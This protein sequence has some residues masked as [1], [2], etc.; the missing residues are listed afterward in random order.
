VLQKRLEVSEGDG[1]TPKA[2]LRLS[3]A[4]NDRAAEAAQ[5]LVSN[6]TGRGAF[7]EFAVPDPDARMIFIS[8]RS[9]RI[10]WL[11][12]KPSR[13]PAMSISTKATSIAIFLS[14]LSTVKASS[15][16]LASM[17]LKPHSLRVSGDDEPDH[18]VAF[19]HK[20]RGFGSG[21]RGAGAL[22]FCIHGEKTSVGGLCSLLLCASLWIIHRWLRRSSLRIRVF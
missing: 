13:L 2:A 16:L 5:H 3:E 19:D 18:H 20:N 12:P 1:D 8:A 6:F 4:V 7:A 11:N 9:R 14:A 21:R 10:H 22:S 17:T 15:A